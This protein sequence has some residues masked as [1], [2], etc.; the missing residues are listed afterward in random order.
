MMLVYQES[1]KKDEISSKKQ[2]NGKMAKPQLQQEQ[3]VSIQYKINSH[4]KLHQNNN[5]SL[6]QQNSNAFIT[7][8]VC[9]TSNN[10]NIQGNNLFSQ[11]NI[12]NMPDQYGDNKKFVFNQYA[13]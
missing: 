9:H 5:Y 13:Q 6:N 3:M 7:V 11:H 2:E 8:P 4:S 10:Y 1:K 12:S